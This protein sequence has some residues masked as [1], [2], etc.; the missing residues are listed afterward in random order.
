MKTLLV[1]FYDYSYYCSAWEYDG[2]N[3]EEVVLTFNQFESIDN[4]KYFRD[5]HP[6][7]KATYTKL[8]KK[9]DKVI[10]CEDGYFE[11]LK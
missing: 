2:E 10:L 4:R 11:V 7:Q 5:F 1:G 6:S 3:I 9:Y 8:L